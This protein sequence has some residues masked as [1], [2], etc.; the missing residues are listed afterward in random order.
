MNTDHLCKSVAYF[1]ITGDES[2]ACI[3]SESGIKAV[4]R[5]AES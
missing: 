2:E 5:F 4:N 3:K 1:M